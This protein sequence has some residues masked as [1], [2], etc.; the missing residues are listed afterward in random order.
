MLSN[1]LRTI[2]QAPRIACGPALFL[3]F[4]L[5]LFAQEDANLKYIDNTYVDYIKTVRL[6]INGFPHSYPL[7]ELGGNAMLRLSFDDL[8]DE[9]RRYSYKFIHCDK[10]WKPSGLSPLEFNS[11]YSKDYLD[12]F[13]FS[14]RTLTEYVHCD[15]VFPNRNM[16]L[17]ASGNYLL[18]VY[19]EEEDIFPVI[20]RRFMV[21]ENVVSISGQVMR[22]ANV[23]KIHTHQEIDVV[24]NVTQLNVKTP[25]RELSLSVVQNNRWDNAII[26]IE[27]NLLKPGIVHFDYQGRV[28]FQGGNEFRNLDIRSVQA[29]RS[30]MVSITNEGDFYAMMMQAENTRDNDTY[31]GY[32]D[33]NGDFVNYRFDRAVFQLADEELQASYGRLDDDFNGEYVE[34]TFVLDTKSPIARDIYI[35]GGLTEWQLKKDFKMVW[36]PNI[37]VYL[38]RAKVKQGFYNYLF[39]TEQQPE[40]GAASQD[41]ISYQGIEG[42]FDETENDYMTLVY[43]RP[44]GGRYDRLVGAKVLNTEVD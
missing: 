41:R 26:G 2:R 3:L 18:V 43:W 34:V 7:I 44:L 15:L 1:L 38:G 13:D 33:L 5:P 10:D 35:F 9:V 19:D 39:V 32:F 29:P 24:A 36:N 40:K 30:Q 17:E 23:D 42:S 21:N 16:K 31:I 12:D 27:P 14:L 8:S 4:S 20:S 25:M 11:G 37:N 6:H 28:S 22:A